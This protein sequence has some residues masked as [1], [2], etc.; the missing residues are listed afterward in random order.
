MLK[1]T[2]EQRITYPN[3][4]TGP[5]PPIPLDRPPQR[6]HPP[7]PTT[8]PPL[9][10]RPRFP[11]LRIRIRIPSS[12]STPL[13]PPTQ[14]PPFK[15]P[16]LQRPQQRTI[17]ISTLIKPNPKSEHQSLTYLNPTPPQKT[18]YPLDLN[19]QTP[20]PGVQRPTTYPRRRVRCQKEECQWCGEAGGKERWGMVG[21]KE[22]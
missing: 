7:P 19:I 16:P 1:R 12:T 4:N 11:G 2:T 3:K 21:R 14:Q 17:S 5:P 8:M 22:Y 9:H 15:P 10:L 20:T 13:L 6:Y 18:L